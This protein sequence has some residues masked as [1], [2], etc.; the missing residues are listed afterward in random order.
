MEGESPAA[1]TLSSEQSSLQRDDSTGSSASGCTSN[2]SNVRHLENAVHI[3]SALGSC[4]EL[5]GPWAL[6]SVQDDY[7]ATVPQT[8][9]TFCL[10]HTPNHE[11]MCTSLDKRAVKQSKR[12][13][14]ALPG[15]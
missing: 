13:S 3:S 5:I 4:G 2:A 9:Q 15:A 6:P 12:V 10:Q 1:G 7:R 8:L 11:D 14:R